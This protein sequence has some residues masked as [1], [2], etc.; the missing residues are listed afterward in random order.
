MPAYRSYRLLLPGGGL[1]LRVRE[2]VCENEYQ[3]E[4]ECFPDVFA[5]IERE[6]RQ[7]NFDSAAMKTVEALDGKL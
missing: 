2:T 1:D 3:D 4:I 6:L 7:C 5:L